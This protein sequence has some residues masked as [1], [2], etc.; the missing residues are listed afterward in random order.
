MASQA[1]V[2]PPCV[3]EDELE[4]LD[5]LMDNSCKVFVKGGSENSYGKVNILLQNY[6]SRCPV[7]TFSL[8]SDQAYIVQNATR[9]LRA[10]FDMV[11]RA[12]GATMAGRMLTLCKVVERQTWNFETPLRQFSELG[13]N[14]LKNIE[15]K[16]LSLEQIRD[17]GCKDI[18]AKLL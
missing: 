2:T 4:E 18:G 17:L 15:E 14:V 3:R 5:F 12:G 11:L 1:L 13:F 7:E 8:V 6:I 10:L 9:I 16:N